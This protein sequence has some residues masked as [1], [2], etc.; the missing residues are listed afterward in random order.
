M[1]QLLTAGSFLV[2]DRKAN[3]L[4]IV[5]FMMCRCWIWVPSSVAYRICACSICCSSSPDS[6]SLVG[7][8]SSL[9]QIKIEK[10][11]GKREIIKCSN[12]EISRPFI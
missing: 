9:Q 11:G 12:P 4:D 7:G 6:S 2:I 10:R 3:M 8:R 1:P 5:I